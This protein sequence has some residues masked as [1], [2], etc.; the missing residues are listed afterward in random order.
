MSYKY[1]GRLDLSDP[2][3]TT[4]NQCLN[5]FKYI[6]TRKLR[7]EFVVFLVGECIFEVNLHSSSYSLQ[8]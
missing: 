6:L 8:I 4:D 1:L 2:N 3:I 5:A 7:V